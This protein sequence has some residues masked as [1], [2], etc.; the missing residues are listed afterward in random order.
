MRGAARAPAVLKQVI[1]GILAG[2]ARKQHADRAN[3]LKS[4]SPGFTQIDRKT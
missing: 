4:H 1:E 3:L 2:A